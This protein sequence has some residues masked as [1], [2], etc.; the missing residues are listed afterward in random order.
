[1]PPVSVF[2]VRSIPKSSAR[3]TVWREVLLV[4]TRII[5][6]RYVR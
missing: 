1:M 2:C 4:F 5:S 3:T 6:H